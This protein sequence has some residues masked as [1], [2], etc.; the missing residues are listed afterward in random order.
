VSRDELLG[1]ARRAVLA[2]AGTAGALGGRVR[3]GEDDGPDAPERDQARPRPA[4]TPG[5]PPRVERDPAPGLPPR[6]ERDATAPAQPPRIEREPEP[7]LPPRVAREPTAGLPPRIERE[8]EHAPAVPPREEE[9]VSP[10][11]PDTVYRPKH[12]R[13]GV[14]PP[15]PAVAPEPDP[16]DVEEPAPHDE[17]DFEGRDDF[18]GDYDDGGEPEPPP[19]GAAVAPRPPVGPVPPR[20]V[21]PPSRRPPPASSTVRGALR[22]HTRFLSVILGLLVVLGIGYFALRI[23]DRI[24]Q[25]SLE[26]QIFQRDGAQNV[27]CS[28]L[29]SNGS[30]WACA[31]IFRAESECLIA[32]VNV[33]GS[34]STVP[35][36]RRCAKIAELVALL[37]QRTTAGGVAAD[38]G[39]QLGI[40]GLTCRKVPEHEVR[41]ACGLPPAPGG[42]CLVARA[43]R[44]QLWPTQLGGRIC[45]HFPA[46]ETAI[47]ASQGEA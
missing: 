29:Q 28:R 41:W 42:Q 15:P 33:L 20:P 24:S 27:R 7:G 10:T 9:E 1:R 38:V 4:P 21:P 45:D 22:P 19:V 31:V 8:P 3:R 40:T 47:R 35:R 17:E 23:H 18:D 26:H 12:A 16:E 46:L 30:A 32:R 6:I 37:P 11:Q 5:L 25:S 43:I 2:V 44:W 36:A 34:W 13:D 14:E 39:Q